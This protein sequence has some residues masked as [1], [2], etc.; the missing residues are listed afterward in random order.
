MKW[1]TRGYGYISA[2]DH[3]TLEKEFLPYDALYAYFR[4]TLEHNGPT[5]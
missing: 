5:T 3:E 1:V 4:Q 2:N